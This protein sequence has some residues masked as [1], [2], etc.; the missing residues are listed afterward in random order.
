M[1]EERRKHDG[2]I[3]RILGHLEGTCEAI[4]THLKSVNET[5]KSQDQRIT[6]VEKRQAWLAGVGTVLG[7]S[8]VALFNKL[9]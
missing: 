5:Q 1:A 7:A 9:F 4:N 6:K 3:M 8:A 2:E